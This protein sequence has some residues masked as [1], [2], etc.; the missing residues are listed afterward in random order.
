ME[1]HPHSHAAHGKK[2]WKSYFWEFIMLFLA[3][4]CGFL[5]EYQLEHMIE[6]KREKQ[7]IQS[8]IEDLKTDTA[9]INKN[10]VFRHVKRGQL[11]S[12]MGLLSEQKIKGY[13]ND[14]YYLGRLLVRTVRFQS[15]D[16][17]ITQLRNSGSLRLIRNEQAADSMIAYQ[18][19][20]E[21]IN[22]NQDDERIERRNV[23]PVLSRMFNSFVFDKMVTIDGIN[24]PADNPHLRSY[25]PAIQQDLAYYIHQIKGS[26]FLIESRLKLLYEKA[27]NAIAFLK[28][29]YHI[30]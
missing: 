4:F 1:V 21:Y 19:L 24:K 7:F 3:V 25:D 6:H 22:S 20:V 10:L 15:N 23:D 30:R 29:E 9:A 8:F 17:T 28:K 26:A 11:D 13:E 5:A 18:K 14:L 27:V 2:T 16:R 12:L